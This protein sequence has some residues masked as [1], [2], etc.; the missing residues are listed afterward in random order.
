MLY[1]NRRPSYYIKVKLFLTFEQLIKRRNQKKL[2]HG[3]KTTI[4]VKK[5]DNNWNKFIDHTI[6]INGNVH[7]KHYTIQNY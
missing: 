3:E 1:L 6:I 5:K 2:Y 4:Q 7:L